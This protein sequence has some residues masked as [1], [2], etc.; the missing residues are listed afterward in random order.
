[1]HPTTRDSAIAA[2]FFCLSVAFATYVGARYTER[3][4]DHEARLRCR[5]VGG[6]PVVVDKYYGW[7]CVGPMEVR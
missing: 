5:E 2:F 1:M 7:R 6:L 3:Q 4:A